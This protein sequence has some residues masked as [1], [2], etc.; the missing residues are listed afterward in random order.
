MSLTNSGNE[1][2]KWRKRSRSAAARASSPESTPPKLVQTRGRD[3]KAR[4][5]VAL[6]SSGDDEL[7]GQL[8]PLAGLA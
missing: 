1:W 4:Q 6:P 8:L 3:P 5:D 2:R 7:V